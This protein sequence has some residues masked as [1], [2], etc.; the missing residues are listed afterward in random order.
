MPPAASGAASRIARHSTVADATVDGVHGAQTR[1]VLGDRS[2][3]SIDR[4]VHSV[5]LVGDWARSSTCWDFASVVRGTSA[6]DGLN[7]SA[8]KLRLLP[9][10]ARVG[11]SDLTV[12]FRL[13]D[14][15]PK[16]GA[17][18]EAAVKSAEATGDLPKQ[19]RR[20]AVF[21]PQAR[22]AP[23]RLLI[24]GLGKA[25]DLDAE[26]IRRAAALAQS[27]A[28]EQG[29]S[30]FELRLELE[31]FAKLEAEQ[32]GAAVSEGLILGAYRYEP[33]RKETPKPR[34]GQRADVRLV[35]GAAVWRRGFESGWELGR[36]GAEAT[37]FARRLADMP[38]N[39][40]TPAYLAAEARKL[41]GGSV[42]VRILERR[43]LEQLGMG[44]LLG[45]ARGSALPP[46][47]IVLDHRPAGA[48]RTVAIVGKGLTFDS[49]G[50]SIK[51]SAKMDE[52]RYDMCG[53]AAVLGLFHA[54]RHGGMSDARR[55]RVLGII[56][57]VENMPDADAQRPGDV[58][59]ACDGTTIE[60]LNTD[61]E[62]RL[63]LAD[64]L[65][66]CKKVYAPDRIVD[67]ATLTGACI[68]ALG[69][70]AAGILG[71]DQELIDELID[72]GTYAAEPLWQL[73][74]WPAHR[75]QMKSRFA[76]L[77]NINS[78][79]DGGG[80]IA[81]AAFLAAFVEGTPWAHLDIAGTAWEGRT[82]DYWRHGATG[83]GVR[84]LLRFLRAQR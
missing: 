22:N 75:E 16:V 30:Q 27:A 25:K 37:A 80:T 5:P 10:T 57:A 24:I 40:A 71:T 2:V 68:V 59:R 62:G 9:A 74:L 69:H 35:G 1:C 11:R 39:L 82:R 54:I 65:A 31:L 70:E 55:L 72:A 46:K 66:W 81:G 47:L 44:A 6:H 73:P 13:E 29:V 36:I 67:L 76:D 38:P 8:M 79:G 42:R 32:V 21:R 49:G 61:A 28:E 77:R 56:A 15:V 34:K 19:F 48:K 3:E 51:P 78:P 20:T 43:A 33:P 63:V 64:A 53:G 58:V 12:A 17:D 14:R 4:P 83:F 84:T 7:H 50:I 18:L 45:V 26:R 60:V 52:M 23:A 41:G